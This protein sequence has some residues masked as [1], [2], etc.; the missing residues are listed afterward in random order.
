MPLYYVSKALLLLLSPFNTDY[1][2][3]QLQNHSLSHKEK[4]YP[5]RTIIESV[6]S[7]HW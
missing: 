7:F 6:R 3:L 4:A 2:H 5:D 1:L